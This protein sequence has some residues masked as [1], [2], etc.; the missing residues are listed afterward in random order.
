MNHVYVF[1]VES[2]S[3]QGFRVDV[4]ARKHEIIVDEPKELRGAD[5][6]LTL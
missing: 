3:K 5:T 6:G 4:R 2:H 1:K